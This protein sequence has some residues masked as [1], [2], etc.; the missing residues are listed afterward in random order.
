MS[1][2][3]ENQILATLLGKEL[4]GL[5]IALAINTDVGL[6]YPALHQLETKGLIQSRWGDEHPESRGGN[7]RRYYRLAATP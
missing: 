3:L 2:N 5:E 1:N 6:L 4:Y 7:R